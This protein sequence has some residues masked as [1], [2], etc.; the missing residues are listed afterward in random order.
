MTATP[1]IDFFPIADPQPWRFSILIPSW[2]NLAYLQC[3]VDSIRRNSAYAHQII[4]HVNDGSD[5]TLDWV[6]AERLDHTY[7]A[8]NVGVCHALNAAAQCVRTD[9]VVYMNDDMFVCPE[10][11]VHLE[12][13]IASCPDHKYYLSATMIEPVKTNNT[14]VLAPYDFGSHPDHFR[15]AELLAQLPQL[16]KADWHGASWPP[17]L[18]HRSLWEEVGGYDVA[19]SLHRMV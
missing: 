14:C 7:S 4:V 1:H 15:E 10:W 8:D 2:N 12:Q 6:N 5:G 3:C 11:D 18:V 17:A 13:A 9:Y 16:H 19:Y